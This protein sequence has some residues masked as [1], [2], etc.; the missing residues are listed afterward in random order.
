[1][2]PGL[3][4]RSV[5]EKVDL[6]DLGL[7]NIGSIETALLRSG[8]RSEV[9]SGGQRPA[10]KVVILP[11]VGHFTSGVEALDTLEMRHT[12]V[13][14]V[15]SGGSLIGICLGMQL[16]GATSE[17]GPGN[18]LSL[19]DFCSRRILADGASGGPVM[20]WRTPKLLEKGW[21]SREGQERYYFMHDYGVTEI[22]SD[23]VK[24]T[25]SVGQEIIASSVGRGRV[26]GFQFHP[27]RSLKF[28]QEILASAVRELSN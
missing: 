20:G 15:N 21:L 1:M 22:N 16:L 24:M 5:S 13:D 8:I 27:E 19:L 23:L 28:G 2:N 9:L 7:G 14:H 4:L 6:I 25:H 17:E 18:G 26:I 11:G 3:T 12:I 10:S